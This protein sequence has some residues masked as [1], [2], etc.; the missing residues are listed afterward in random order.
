MHVFDLPAALRDRLSSLNAPTVELRVLMRATYREVQSFT[1]GVPTFTTPTVWQTFTEDM[2]N[3]LVGS[4]SFNSEKAYFPN[5]GNIDDLRS[6]E[7]TLVFANQD[8]YI[9]TTQGGAMIRLSDITDAE[10]TIQAIVGG[11]TTN[12]INLFKGKA[13]GP[14][15]EERGYT[16]FTI[17]NTLWDAIKKPALCEDF[18]SVVPQGGQSIIV[19]NASIVATHRSIDTQAGGH[20][21]IYNSA[22]KWDFQGQP[23]PDIKNSDSSKIDFKSISSI[24]TNAKPG[25]YLIEFIDATNYTVTYPDNS[26][27]RGSVTM[28]FASPFLSIPSSSWTTQDGAGVKIE[29]FVGPCMKGNPISIARNFVEKALVGNWGAVPANTLNVRM[30][31]ASWDDAEYRFRSYTIGMKETNESNS[32]WQLARGSNDMPLSCLELANRALAHV[33]CFMQ[34]RS[35]GLIGIVTPFFDG[36]RFWDLTDTNAI[37][38]IKIEP[39]QQWNYLIAKYGR[40]GNKTYTQSIFLDYRDSTT[41]GINEQ[42]VSL[43]YYPAGCGKVRA[44]WLLNTYG[45]RY[46]PRQMQVQISMIPQMAITLQVGDIVRIVTA[47]QPRLQLMCEI[48]SLSIKV[49]DVCTA[50][51]LPVQQYEGNA[52]ELCVAKVNRELLW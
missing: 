19:Q 1:A 46:Q 25:T 40:S 6:G 32:C 30:D 21:C 37:T 9:A 26:Q 48:Q 47:T 23:I 10:F 44:K 28:N 12:P 36:R 33:G 4:P 14:P 20:F 18:A 31:A 15:R 2:S 51:L 39:A 8:E 17:A 13:I 27:Y 42:V 34:M 3:R 43:P 29:M 52:F 35:D 45:R 24:A 49:D 50:V 16:T 41:S 38:D 5:A 11:Y 22:A 7:I